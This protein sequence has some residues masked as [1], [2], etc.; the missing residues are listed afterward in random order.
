VSWRLNIEELTSYIQGDTHVLCSFS[1]YQYLHLVFFH[2]L[3]PLR[4]LLCYTFRPSICSQSSPIHTY[5]ICYQTIS[6]H[7]DISSLSSLR[8]LNYFHVFLSLKL[9]AIS[10]L[11]RSMGVQWLNTGHQCNTPRITFVCSLAC[12]PTRPSR[13]T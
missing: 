10:F 2:P 13:I 4:S 6:F 3:I 5:L 12:L 7:T 11:I 1:Y 8:V 9:F